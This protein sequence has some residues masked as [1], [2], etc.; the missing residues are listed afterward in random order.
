M[1]DMAP[2]QAFAIGGPGSVRGYTEGAIGSGRSYLVTNNE[3]TVP[4]VKANLLS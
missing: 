4:L 2:Y 3:L 1:G